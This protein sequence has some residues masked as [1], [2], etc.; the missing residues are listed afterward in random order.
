MLSLQIGRPVVD[1]TGLTGVYDFNLRWSRLSAEA[2]PAGSG[3]PLQGGAPAPTGSG[4][5]LFGAFEKQL[6]L[7]LEPAKDPIQVLVVDK[8]NR[9][10]AEN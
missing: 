8:G 6:G 9:I 7:K 5:D 4:L 2:G 10:P 1:K 3:D